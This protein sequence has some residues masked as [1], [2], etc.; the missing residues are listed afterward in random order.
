MTKSTAAFRGEP[1]G[2]PVLE[3]AGRLFRERGFEAATVRQIADAAGILP[4]SLHYRYR[5]K[6]ELLLALLDRGIARATSAVRL[7]IADVADPVE[8]MRLALRAH[9]RLLVRD[10]V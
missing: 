6:E 10:D 3:I 8:R 2:D 1:G 7:A 4:G 5:S 9:L